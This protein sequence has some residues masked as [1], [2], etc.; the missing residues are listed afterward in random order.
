MQVR[1]CSCAYAILLNFALMYFIY[2]KY[3]KFEGNEAKID[4]ADTNKCSGRQ[5]QL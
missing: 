3:S 2:R 5:Y 1:L 4:R